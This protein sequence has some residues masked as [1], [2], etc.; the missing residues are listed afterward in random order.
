LVV[1]IKVW[2]HTT[3]T[4]PLFYQINYSFLQNRNL[5]VDTKLKR[6]SIEENID[7]PNWERLFNE[8][9]FDPHFWERL[10]AKNPTVMPYPLED[11]AIIWKP[12]PID[13]GG[14]REIDDR[15]IRV[16]YGGSNFLKV[17]K[18]KNGYRLSN[19]YK[20]Y[21]YSSNFDEFPLILIHNNG[22]LSFFA[23]TYLNYREQVE[24]YWIP[25]HWDEDKS[26]LEN[27]GTLLRVPQG[28][29][30]EWI[31]ESLKLGGLLNS[32]ALKEL[33]LEKLVSWWKIPETPPKI[34]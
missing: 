19:G 9:D 12:Y 16:I 11:D 24:H 13:K 15:G 21:N 27:G 31:R 29:V 17:Q 10:S 18:F 3:R 20:I 26:I 5:E 6:P 7:N 22:Q 34:Y 1:G 25:V 2:L 32:K 14:P 8:N 28:N 4:R 23:I 33:K 30:P